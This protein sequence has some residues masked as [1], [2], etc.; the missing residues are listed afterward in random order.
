MAARS[1]RQ[2]SSP[3]E[4]IRVLEVAG[5]LA[6]PSCAA[7]LGDMGATVTKVEPLGGD[8]WRAFPPALDGE[9]AINWNPGFNFDNRGK[10]SIAVDLARPDGQ[11]IVHDLARRADV[12]ITNL[13]PGRAR[14]Y[15]LAYSS[16]ARLNARLV[17]L[18]FTGYGVNGPD[19]DR[20]GFDDVAFWAGTGIMA[21]L[22]ETGRSPVI[23][24]NSLGDHTSALGLLA[25]V[26]TALFHRERT[27][28]GQFLQASLFSTGLWTLGDAVQGVLETGRRPAPHAR[29][30][31]SNALF[32]CYRLRDGRW[33]M[34]AMDTGSFWP[35]VARALDIDPALADD[36]EL[37]TFDG[38]AT[39][40]ARLFPVLE[41]ALGR[42]TL[43]QLRSR[44]RGKHVIWSAVRFVDEALQDPQVAANDMVAA[45]PGSDLR[46]LNLPVR[47]ERS[48]VEPRGPVPGIGE[49]TDEVLSEL[50]RD[51]AAITRLREDGVVR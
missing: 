17:Y 50:G 38:P 14:R 26:M 35:T 49:H 18:Q 33:V 23:N 24:Q 20:P 9:A 28:E 51:D 8:P 5:W 13:T 30:A 7:L 10:R 37:A 34:L 44:F 4:G 12:F 6:A 29:T 21:N 1:R 42:L 47:F 36:P 43:R 45:V 27:G 16:L 11:A 22:T 19:R 2:Q 40:A 3:L 15:A 48:R 25:G 32:D 41:S 39:Q 46:V 31:P